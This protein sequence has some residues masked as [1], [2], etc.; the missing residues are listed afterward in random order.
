MQTGFCYES[1][2]GKIIIVDNGVAITYIDFG[3]KFEEEVEIKESVLTKETF[4]QL[5]EYFNG[6]RKEFNLPLDPVGTKFQKSVWMALLNI[7][8]GETRTYKEIA[9]KVGNEKGAR[10][11]GMANN[12]NPISII[13]PCHRVIGSNKKLVGYAGGLHIK[14]KLLDLERLNK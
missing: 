9:I 13:I 10:A 11:V 3:D 14:E 2:M 4:K 5:S 6:K 8:Y 12:K 7:P 1:N